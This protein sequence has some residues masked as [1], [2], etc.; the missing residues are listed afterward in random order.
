MCYKILHC[1]FLNTFY[2]LLFW[3]INNLVLVNQFPSSFIWRVENF[4]KFPIINCRSILPWNI[5]TGLSRTMIHS[6]S[7]LQYSVHIESKIYSMLSIGEERSSAATDNA[8]ALTVLLL[9]TSS[10]LFPALDMSTRSSN[11]P[12]QIFSDVFLIFW[13]ASC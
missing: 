4:R 7:V 9:I 11:T 13:K 5:G 10:I 6:S 1:S 8:S 3:K 12:F 2:H